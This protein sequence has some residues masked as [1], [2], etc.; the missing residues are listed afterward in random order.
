MGKA[1][2]DLDRIAETS[3]GEGRT[4]QVGA[5]CRDRSVALQSQTVKATRSDSD[6]VRKTVKNRC[7]PGTVVTP[8][9]A[10]W[11]GESSG[12]KHEEQ[13]QSRER[14][15]DKGKDS[16]KD[17]GLGKGRGPSGLLSVT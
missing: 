2:R 10:D 7:L 16:H 6:D 8:R 15:S 17:L 13:T 12:G 3:G 5:F 9:Y 14:S 1:G 11:L 4:A